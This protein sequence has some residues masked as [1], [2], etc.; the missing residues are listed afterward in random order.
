EIYSINTQGVINR[1][2]ANQEI[3]ENDIQNVLDSAKSSLHLIDREI[4][5]IFPQKFILDD[6][7]EVTEPIGMLAKKISVNAHIITCPSSL[8]HNLQ[9]AIIK[10]GYNPTALVLNQIAASSVLLTKDQKK[11]GVILVDIGASTINIALFIQGYIW[12]TS[13]KI[14]AGNIITRDLAVNFRIPFAEAERLKEKECN[15][16]NNDESVLKVKALGSRQEKLI[17]LADLNNICRARIKEIID[18]IVIDIINTNINESIPVGIVFCGGTAKLKGLCE[19]LSSVIKTTPFNIGHIN[20]NIKGRKEVINNPNNAAVL[21]L[22][23][24]AKNN[25]KSNDFTSKIFNNYSEF[26]IF[27]D[28]VK[29]KIKN[30][31]TNIKEKF[32]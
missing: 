26:S 30:V 14:P 24:Y 32:F 5:H 23:E 12:H 22:L 31:I 20:A 13:V 29:Y 7:I 11:L 10:L 3:S 6:Q 28:E 18:I 27:N 9:R 8:L 15:L 25:I 17:K 2:K 19:Y 1:I 16:I 21:G 4:L